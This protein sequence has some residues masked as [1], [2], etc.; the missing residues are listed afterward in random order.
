MSAFVSGEPPSRLIRPHCEGMHP[1]FKRMR[2]PH[3]KVVEMRTQGTRTFGFFH[4]PNVF[5]AHVVVAADVV[6]HEAAGY[7]LRAAAVED[8]KSR[9][10]LRSTNFASV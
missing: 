7:E 6:K 9:L 4:C 10:R 5:V 2:P 8:L 3:V 1:T